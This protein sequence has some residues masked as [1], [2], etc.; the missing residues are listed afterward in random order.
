[1]AHK[2]L[3]K[4]KNTVTVKILNQEYKVATDSDPT[5]A[6]KVAKFLNDNI[7]EVMSKSATTP[8]F[9]ALVL[10]AL[11]ITDKYFAIQDRHNQFK[12]KMNDKSQMIL[13]LLEKATEQNN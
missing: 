6:V 13:D 4:K 7:K 3:T 12:M 2:T 11:N 1:M 5:R 8:E 10:A 9:K